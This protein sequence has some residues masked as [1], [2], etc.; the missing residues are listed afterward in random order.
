MLHIA[1]A[2]L[3]VIAPGQAQTSDPA[4]PPPHKEKKICRSED[5]TGSIM[6]RRTCHTAEEWQQIDKS[7]GVDENQ[8]NHL[9][10]RLH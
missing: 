1:I 7:R 6:P 8:M 3:A 4:N 10:G 2:A 9:R 5:V